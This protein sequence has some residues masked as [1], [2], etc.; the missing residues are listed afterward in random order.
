MPGKHGNGPFDN[1]YYEEQNEAA[2]SFDPS[3]DVSQRAI[4]NAQTL[5]QI[6]RKIKV[7]F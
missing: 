7:F 4:N 2:P 3:L 1:N 6:M 5:I